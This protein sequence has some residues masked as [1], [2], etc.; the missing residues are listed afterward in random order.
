MRGV[1]SYR[2][3]TTPTYTYLITRARKH[4]ALYVYKRSTRYNTRARRQYVHIT[5]GKERMNVYESEEEERSRRVE[6]RKSRD[7]YI[8]IRGDSHNPIDANTRTRFLRDARTEFLSFITLDTLARVSRYL[9][10]EE[11][12]AAC[13][14]TTET[15]CNYRSRG[16]RRISNAVVCSSRFDMQSQ[17]RRNF[18]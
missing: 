18:K 11:E 7:V 3:F 1:K 8:N 9:G 5:R 6:M 2:Q 15:V 12:E 14:S 4:T 13:K 10:E 16:T 17:P